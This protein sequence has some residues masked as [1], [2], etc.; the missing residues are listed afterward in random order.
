MRFILPLHGDC[1]RISSSDL[2]HPSF[3]ENYEP[4]PIAHPAHDIPDRSIKSPLVRLCCPSLS[5][6]LQCRPIDY[7]LPQE[8]DQATAQSEKDAEERKHTPRRQSH[9][10]THVATQL[11]IQKHLKR[12]SNAPG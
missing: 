10:Q 2:Y 8:M 1:N 3:A 6:S 11:N 9:R 7:V 12:K 5:I 4:K